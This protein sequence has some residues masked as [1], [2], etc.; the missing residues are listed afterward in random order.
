[1]R[2]IQEL[3]DTTA[4]TYSE[5]YDPQRDV[6]GLDIGVG[7]SCIYPLL[8]CSSRPRWRM[9]G[10]DIDP[11]SLD[12]ARRNVERNALQ[13]R[14]RLSA[15][16]VDADSPLMPLDALKL[17]KL[18]FVMTNPPFYSSREEMQRGYAG[19]LAAP[20]AVCTGAQH[21]MICPGGEV[22]FV[23]RLMEESLRLRNRVQWYTAMLG[24]LP[25]L[26]RVV[27]LLKERG[28]RNFAVASLQAGRRTNRWAVGWS[29]G[30]FR[31][32][33]DVA[34]HGQ[35]AGGVL[36]LPA[37]QT[38]AAPLSGVGPAREKVDAVLKR[39][40][41][42]W[43]WKEGSAMGLMEARENVWSRA[44]RRRRKRG[45]EAPG[46]SGCELE[47]AR[48]GTAVDDDDV[49]NDNEDEEEEEEEEKGENVALAVMISYR[50]EEVN[51]RWLRGNDY[52][53]FESFCGML[54]RELRNRG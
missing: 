13:P 37:T 9:A 29:L 31:P 47:S 54:K 34:R 45:A 41:V 44:A 26:H 22:G 16:S 5:H 36:P 18:D 49:D 17:V 19:K 46:H 35:L 24:K 21:E 23:T 33:N 48:D 20:S 4:D 7:A 43:R 27:A 15:V 32:R 38:I 3:L 11:H 51:V 40:E 8:A 39:L 1:M 14:I 28:I 12:Y 30:D 2:W 53:L 50:I 6:V 42:K 25:S 52:V 10:T